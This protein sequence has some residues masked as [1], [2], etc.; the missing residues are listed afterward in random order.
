MCL[1]GYGKTSLRKDFPRGV[2]DRDF[3]RLRFGHKVNRDD[4]FDDGYALFDIG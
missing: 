4:F 1:Q 3:I 2:C